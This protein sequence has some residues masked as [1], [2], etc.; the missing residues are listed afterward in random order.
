MAPHCASLQLEMRRIEARQNRVDSD[1]SFRFKFVFSFECP[2]QTE[3]PWKWQEL[4]LE[5][6]EDVVEFG[7]FEAGVS[8]IPSSSGPPEPDETEAIGT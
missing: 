6:L 5:Q 7:M 8:T 3:L 4:E 2:P 1:V